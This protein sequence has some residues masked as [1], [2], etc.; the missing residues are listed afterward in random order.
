MK[1][2][3]TIVRSI[4]DKLIRDTAFEYKLEVAPVNTS[5]TNETIDGLQF[6]DF[7]RTFGLGRPAL[8]YAWTQLIAP[9]DMEMTIQIE[10]NDGC[11]I[12]LNGE[13]IYLSK[14]NRDIHLVFDERS[15]ELSHE[16]TLI[17]RKG[18]NTLLVKSE[19]RGPEWR[20]Y[21]QPPSLKGAIVSDAPQPK[22]GLKDVKNIDAKVA[23]L[24]NWLVV[25]P[26]EN[27]AR[28]L[29]AIHAPEREFV[30]GT[31][32]PGLDG[33]VTWTIPKIEIHGAIIDKQPW[34]SHY[35]W[36]YYN[37]GTAWAMQHLAEVTGESKY[38]EYANAFCDYHLKGIPFVEYQV[39]R[40]NALESANHF[41]IETPLLDFTL[42]PSVPFVNRLRKEKQFENCD[43]YEKWVE[44][45]LDYA[46]TGQIRLPGHG[47]YTRITPVEYTTWVDDMFMG[48]PFLVQASLYA[49]DE[50]SR[51][52]FLDDAASQTLAFNTQVWDEE[53]ELYMHARYSNNPVKLP[54]W[55][56]CNGWAIV[57][58]SEVLLHLPEDHPRRAAILEQFRRHARSLARHQT[59]EGFWL[60]VLDRKDSRPEVSGTAIFTFAIARGVI[61]GWLDAGEFT[62]V[63]LNGWKALETQIESDGTVHNICEGTMCS[64]DV[65]Y[66]MNR[67]LYDNDTHGLFAVLFAGIEMDRLLKKG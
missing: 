67:P 34:G 5:F 15:L 2:P 9:C 38:R 35:N 52:E 25:G 65:N 64:E 18:A 6:V 61:N 4:G 17:L 53:A 20:F 28:D 29:D 32:Y 30:F 7:G 31:M 27:S 66:Y 23:S 50:K 26:F 54:H 41:I 59:P 47:I 46:R 44:R 10:H 39:K 49:P 56:R 37:G 13:Q 33:T 14:G 62:S 57:T 55:S 36:T 42:A 60:N 1:S 51:K 19:T 43:L 22:I 58:M 45:M 40:L 21:L 63:A 3:L 11:K 8:A 12:W 24:T 48:I 16:C